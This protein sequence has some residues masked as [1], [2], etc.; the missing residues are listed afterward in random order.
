MRALPLNTIL[1]GDVRERLA[2]LPDAAVDC[3]V[4]SPPYWALRDYGHNG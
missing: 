1:I 4:T 3:I 2:E